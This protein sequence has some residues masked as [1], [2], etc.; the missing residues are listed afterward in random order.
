MR[1]A[2]CGDEIVL[3]RRQLFMLPTRYGI[4]FTLLL[5]ALLLASINYNNGL[6]YGLTFLLAAMGF[7]SMLYTH[8]NIHGLRVT[9]GDSVPVFTGE[10]AMFPVWLHNETQQPRLGMSILLGNKTV[11]T[12]DLAA[13]QQ[14]QANIPL[15]THERGYLTTPDFVLTTTFPLGLLYSWSRRIHL[16][17]RILIYPKAK[18]SQALPMSGGGTAGSDPG[19]RPEGDDFAGLREF[20]NGDAPQH[21]SW[22][23][24]ARGYGLYTK[25]FHGTKRQ[26]L[27]LR[28][29][30]LHAAGLEA[31]LSQLCSWVLQAEQAGH[32]YGLQL[33]QL[34]IAP[35]HGSRQRHRC[36]KALALYN[37]RP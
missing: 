22:K 3:G 37:S 20:R 26:T 12:L 31:R 8:R 35:A 27:W 6:A 36:L 7:V 16:S 5:F 25:Q 17:H 11:A 18:G 24:A 28:W 10:M 19:M 15:A 32:N 30:D 23:A 29:Q 34:R 33:P 4:M 9:A 21:I 2:L 13:Q 1:P 14:L